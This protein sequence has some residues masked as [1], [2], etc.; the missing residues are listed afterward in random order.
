MSYHTFYDTETT[1][2]TPRFDQVLQAAAI[3]TDDDFVEI[4]AIDERSRLAGHIVPT[5]GALKVTHVDPYEIAR[6]KHSAYEFAKMLHDTFTSWQKRGQEMSFTGYNTIRFDEEIMRQM[7][8]ENLLD[9]YI[10][11]GKG[12]YRND[13]LTVVRALYARNPDCIEIP[14]R[15]DGRNNFKLEN[16]APL[17]GFAGHDAHDALGDVRATIHIARL[18]RDTDMALWEHMFRMGNAKNATD[19][20]DNEV[21]FRLLGGQML[22]PGILDVCL[23]ASEAANPKSKTA[24]NLAV[25]PTPYLD[26]SAEEILGAMRK[27]GTPFRT[28]K[29]NKQPAAFP[30]N[31]EFLARVSNDSFEPADTATI[32]ERSDLIRMHQGFQ[33]QTQEA[34]RLKTEGYDAPETLEEKIYS[35]FPDWNDKNRMTEFHHAADWADKYNIV[36]SLENKNMRALGVR[37]VYLNAPQ[38]LSPALRNGCAL[39]VAEERFCLDTN[40]AWTTVGSLMKE[41]DEWFL[42]EPGDP[43]LLNIQK[44]ALETYPTASEWTGVP[45]EAEVSEDAA[46]EATEVAVQGDTSAGEAKPACAKVNTADRHGQIEPASSDPDVAAPDGANSEQQFK[47]V[48]QVQEAAVHFLDGLI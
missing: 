43:E 18:I 7:F 23:I 1:G 42:A 37:T 19:F 6:A 3:L 44:W 27:T 21:V 11:S 38:V 36:K 12:T 34:L 28:V 31:W 16:L 39:K 48:R 24:W 30:I 47:A 26:M 35:G 25:D 15:E 40:K 29:C 22:N 45:P 14:K 10:T 41:L 32:Q 4:E 13:L 9:P 2:P 46:D 5:A 8:W 17:N 33:A 20:V